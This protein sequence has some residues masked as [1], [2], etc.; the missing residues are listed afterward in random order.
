MEEKKTDRRT[1]KTRKAICD[2]LMGFLTEKELNKVT[3][4]EISDKADINRATF[5]KHYLDVYDL[6]DKLEQDILIEWG[7]LVLKLQELRTEDF[8][9]K[10]VDY[11]DKNRLMSEACR[12]E[13]GRVWVWR[14]NPE[15]G[16]KERWYFLEDMYPAY[17][18]LVPRDVASRAIYKV[19]VH[20]GLGM[21]EPNRVYLDLSHIDRDY[22][23]RKLGGILEMY[24]DFVGKSPADVPMEIF[25]SVHYSMGGIWVDRLHHTNI[26]GLM[27]SGTVSGPEAHRWARSGELG[28]PLTEAEMEAARK[29]CVAEFDKIRNMNGPENAHKL[30]HEMGEIMYKYVSIE[31]DNIGLDQCLKELK[32][33]LKRWDNIGVTDHGNWANQEAMFVRQLRNMILYAMVVTKGARCRDESRGAHA[34]IVL[35]ENGN[36]KTDEQGELVFMGR[37]DE[38]FMKTT[39]VDYDPKTEEPQVSYME[40]DHSLIKPRARN[41]A[42]A[43]KE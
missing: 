35:D 2:A 13:G 42:V 29:E 12:G 32:E 37:D 3:V 33:I 25:P 1:L 16:E 20:M 30:H 21:H 26:P 6:Y 17:G 39:I 34:K 41:Y 23:E 5:Y 19:C 4:Q 40:F 36:R 28:D 9:K 15:T 27:A 31:R 24:T 18:N 22:L 11:V 43:K 10:L 7:M 38:R 14:D 8:F